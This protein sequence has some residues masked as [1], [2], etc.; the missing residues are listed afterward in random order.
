MHVPIIETERLYLRGF[1]TEDLDEL[2]GILSKPTVMRYMPGSEPFSQ[3]RA[4]KALQS[5]MRH[6]EEHGFGWWAVMQRE[7]SQLIG[8]C[9]LTFVEELE[10]TEVAYLLD[11]PFWGK[12]IATEGTLAGLRYGFE[13]VGL[14]HIIA[15]AHVDNIASRRVM[16]K[17]GMTYVADL[18]LWGFELAKYIISRADHHAG[19]GRY[20][21]RSTSR[22]GNR[23]AFQDSGESA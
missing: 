9:G 22:P 3:E 20:E 23:K 10:E 12:G 15:L 18:R 8:W 7:H 16:E 14:E 13:N 19:P 21:L 4:E 2:A 17:S 6:W 1:E 5:I 11:E